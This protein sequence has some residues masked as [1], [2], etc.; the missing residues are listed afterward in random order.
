ML[1]VPWSGSYDGFP[2]Y[3]NGIGLVRCFTDE[4]RS[5]AKDL[6]AAVK[7]WRRESAARRPEERRLTLVTGTLFAPA[8]E[9]LIASLEDG[10]V[11]RVLAVPNHFFGGNVS[12]AGL[13]TDADLSAAI[14]ADDAPG[15]YLVPDVVG[16]PEGLT[17]DDVPVSDLGPLTG[18]DV[19]LVSS[20]AAGLLAGVRSAIDHPPVTRPKSR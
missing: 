3:E 15:V 14:R 17:L 8:L 5:S 10:D 12:V 9:S 2:Q 19:R 20:D 6:A 7:D 18:H 1:P 11:F 4:L 13:L 16:N